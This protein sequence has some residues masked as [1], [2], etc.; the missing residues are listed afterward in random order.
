V[1]TLSNRPPHSLPETVRRVYKNRGKLCASLPAEPSR[2]QRKQHST[3]A[4]TGTGGG[5][6]AVFF[7]L[8]SFARKSKKE[9]IALD[10]FPSGA[11]TG[12]NL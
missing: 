11:Y 5:P 9:E 2:Q 6:T 4:N 7:P 10:T 1:A 8:W 3:Y 12:A